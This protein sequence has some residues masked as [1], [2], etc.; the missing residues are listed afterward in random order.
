MAY[1][2][3]VAGWGGGGAC[4]VLDRRGCDAGVGRVVRIRC[5]VGVLLVVVL[6]EW[7]GYI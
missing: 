1:G 2:V 7:G 4:M 3:L 6:G 5:L